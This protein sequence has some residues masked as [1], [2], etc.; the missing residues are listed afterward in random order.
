M[1]TGKKAASDAAKVL[2]D[3]KATPAEKKAA[4]SDLSQ[5][6]KKLEQRASASMGSEPVDADARL[7]STDH[8]AS[9]SSSLAGVPSTKARRDSF[10]SSPRRI[11]CL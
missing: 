11:A 10:S 7:A 5:A 4:A 6:K 3:S 9:V 8:A 1:A 2:K